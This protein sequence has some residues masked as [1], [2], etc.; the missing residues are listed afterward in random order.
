[1][2]CLIISCLF[3]GSANSKPREEL[4]IVNAGDLV[5]FNVQLGQTPQFSGGH[6][7]V[8]VGPINISVPDDVI[9]SQTQ[10]TRTS[11]TDTIANQNA[12]K[13]SVRIPGDAPNGV[14]EAFF[15]FAV[16]NG[17]Y[18]PLRHARQIFRVHRQDFSGVPENATIGLD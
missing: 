3:Q 10:Y 18:F 7:T 12:Y 17:S 8:L 6:V 9:V 2:S 14:W 1:M 5:T 13:V 11:S 16:P 4:K 15:S